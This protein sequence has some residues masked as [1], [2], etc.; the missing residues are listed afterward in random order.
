MIC[1]HGNRQRGDD[2]GGREVRGQSP[3]R[4]FFRCV[5]EW[6]HMLPVRSW[7]GNGVRGNGTGLA[8]IVG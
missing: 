6:V 2:T 7:N 5:C 3:L 8:G 4:G 1:R